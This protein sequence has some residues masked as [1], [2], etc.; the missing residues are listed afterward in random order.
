MKVILPKSDLSITDE[1]NIVHCKFYL[2]ISKVLGDRTLFVRVWPQ[3][4]AKTG[5]S[6]KC[7]LFT[8]DGNI[9]HSTVHDMLNNYK[10]YEVDNKKIKIE[11][12]S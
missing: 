9:F 7:I 3:Y 4:S 11:L 6:D 5:R 10:I 8:E 12:E 1:A 2:G